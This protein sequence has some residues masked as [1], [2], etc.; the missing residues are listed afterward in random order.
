MIELEP[1]PKPKP[2]PK[3]EVTGQPKPVPKQPNVSAAT[4]QK[5]TPKPVSQGSP[6]KKILPQNEKENIVTKKLKIEVKETQQK[7]VEMVENKD[8]AKQEET[9]N[10]NGSG[11]KKIDLVPVEKKMEMIK[12]HLGWQ[13]AGS[14]TNPILLEALQKLGIPVK[15]KGKKEILIDKLYE[16]LITLDKL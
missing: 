9:K 7:D 4:T 14:P 11:M 5:N 13:K 6:Q 1:T 8:N 10:S 15:G 2:I 16:H 12:V 3:K